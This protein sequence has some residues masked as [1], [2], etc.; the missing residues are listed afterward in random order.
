MAGEA[1]ANVLTHLL[2]QTFEEVGEKVALY[3]DARRRAGRA[4]R[5]VVSLMLHTYVSEDGESIREIVRGPMK[6]YLATAMSLVKEAAWHFPTFKQKVQ[7]SGKSLDEVLQS[8]LSDEER[9]AVLDFAFERY[10][11][12][13]GLFGTPE[14]CVEAVA[15]AAAADVDE[16]A[17]LIDFGV[18][19]DLALD[20]L[21]HLARVRELSSIVPAAAANGTPAGADGDFGVAALIRRFGV[22]HLQCTPSMAGMLLQDEATR[23]AFAALRVVLLGGEA[24]PEPLARDVASATRARVVNMYGPTETTIWSSTHEVRAE[25]GTAAIGRPIANTR[26]YV[27]DANLEPMPVGVPGELLIGGAGVVRGY[28]ERP[29]LNAERF[30]P[31]PFRPGERVYRTGDLA[32][33]RDDGV[34]EFLG[35]IDHQVKIRGYRIELGEIEAHLAEHAAVREAVVVAREDAPGEKRLVAY[36]VPGAG[37]AEDGALREHLRARL[38]EYMVPAAFVALDRFPLTPNAKVDRKALPAPEKG[39]RA[40]RGA[41]PSAPPQSELQRRIAGVWR[42]ALQIEDVGLDDNFFDLG[43]HSLLAVRVHRELKE[44]APRALS[45]TDL[46][47]LPTVRVLSAFLAGEDEGDRIAKQSG[48]R[49]AARRAA[50]AQRREARRGGRGEA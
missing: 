5:G 3:R 30:V 43:G 6:R 41:A 28:R 18:P 36:Y 46:F 7:E 45:I 10:Y 32:R 47:R 14:S 21:K 29:E 44:M 16:I 39:R 2:G 13:S 17:C 24:L 23:E 50:L 8:G 38:P 33:L 37:A 12:T 19:T 26:F 20:G 35:R 40:A 11:E 22:T 27:V 49:A 34:V 4:G 42:E 25:E 15:R 9:E 1:G 48:A 31:D